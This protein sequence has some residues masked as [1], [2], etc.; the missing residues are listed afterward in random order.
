MTLR[1]IQISLRVVMFASHILQINRQF[2]GSLQHATL[3]YNRFTHIDT[4]ST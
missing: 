4:T 2:H 1:V 3:L